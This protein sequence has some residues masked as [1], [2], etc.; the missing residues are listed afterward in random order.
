VDLD[1]VGR[2]R[3]EVL[4]EGKMAAWMQCNGTRTIAGG[5]ETKEMG[6]MTSFDKGSGH[7][8]ILV[9]EMKTTSLV[10]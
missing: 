4:I 2:L 6:E 8:V 3:G 7:F 5:L 1:G 10:P 9:K